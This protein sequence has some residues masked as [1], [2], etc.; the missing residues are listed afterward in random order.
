MI[1][2]L[3]CFFL[4]ELPDDVRDLIELCLQI[5][6]SS[7]PTSKEVIEHKLFASTKVISEKKK[8]AGLLGCK[9]SLLYHWWQL[10]GGDIQVELK[11]QGLIKCSPAI[12]SMPM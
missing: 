6:P 8:F 1:L 9:M 3:T 4:Q 2:V 10:A 11:K 12:L 5:S 7:R